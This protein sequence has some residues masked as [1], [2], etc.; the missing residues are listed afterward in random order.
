M[1]H[2]RGEE[3]HVGRPETQ[4]PADVARELG[5]D[6]GMVFVAAL[7]D[8]VHERPE[9]QQV[10]PRHPRGQ[11]RGLPGDLDQVA[12]D[13]PHV[14]AVAG[15]QVPHGAPLGEEAAPQPGAVEGLHDVDHPGPA[16]EQGE[17]LGARGPG[18]RLPQLRSRVGEATQRAG[19]H[20]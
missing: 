13:G 18:P 5:A 8:V 16:A 4:A 6:H 2:H 12:V 9:Q 19:G 11:P 1:A 10:R 20:R 17:Q 15:R 3:V 14:L 7:A